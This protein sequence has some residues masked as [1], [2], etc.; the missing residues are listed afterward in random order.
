MRA[1]QILK[2]FKEKIES[3]R[4]RVGV[5]GLGYV[6]L[7]LAVEFAQ[8]GFR[9]TGIDV[10]AGT[11]KGVN[12][13]SSHIADVAS[14]DLRP[15]VR[16]KMLRA[17]TD[18]RAL[19]TV[20]AVSI[21]VPTPLR[22][23]GDPDI[24]YIV[25]AVSN[26]SSYL[27]EGMLVV[28]ESTTYP[29]TTTEILL[30]QLVSSGM[31][32]GRHFFLAFSPE[33]VD[34]GRI[35]YT[36]GNTPK[37]LGGVTP[38]CGQAAKALYGAVVDRV[39]QVS[40]PQ[41]AE[42]VKLLENT[43]RSVNIGLVNEIALICDRLGLD[44]WEIIDAAATKP[45]GFMPFYPGP[46]LGGHCIPVDPHYLSWKLRALNFNARFIELAGEINSK[47]PQVV[48]ERI[49]QALNERRKPL[50]GSKIHL[51]GV[52]YKKDVSDTRESPALDVIALLDQAGA[53]V[54]YSDPF[55]P[56]IS[57][58]SMKLRSQGPTPARL[59]RA[60][61]VVIL[62]DHTDFDYRT[63]VKSSTLVVDTR[64][65]VANAGIRPLKKVVKL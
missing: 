48:V 16:K 23:T 1:A 52:A 2:E 34:P 22:K 61:V 62:T 49:A 59:K 38:R 25:D 13:G 26:V 46:G 7:P 51:L 28:L 36:T 32:A 42:M 45:F 10:A 64:N 31:K 58:D 55:V 11:V 43:F 17:T 57:L 44:V 24:S 50:K 30:P 9:V 40:S 65:A 39:V 29:G 14:A 20:D 54:S 63:I 47:M 35:D 4:A 19:K 5:I 15:L 41:A 18:F 37:V 3:R 27:H 8:A 56:R 60:D 12:R 6:G 33:R 21:C 53:S